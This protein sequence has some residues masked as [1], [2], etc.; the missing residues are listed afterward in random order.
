MHF[1]AADRD[2][3]LLIAKRFFSQRLEEAPDRIDRAELSDADG[4]MFWE[5]RNP[6]A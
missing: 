1:D 4:A 2:E 3:A 5:G 6:N